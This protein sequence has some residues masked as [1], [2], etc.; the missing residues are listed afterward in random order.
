MAT[1]SE[2]ATIK[3]QAD[4]TGLGISEYIRRQL[5]ERPELAPDGKPVTSGLPISEELLLEV[6]QCVLVNNDLWKEHHDSDPVLKERFERIT[7]KVARD[8]GMRKGPG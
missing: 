7:K 8:I 2:W 1:D 6:V 4:R 3:A 5:L